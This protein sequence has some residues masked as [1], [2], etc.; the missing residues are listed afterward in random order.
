MSV[1]NCGSEMEDVLGS[2][3]PLNGAFLLQ[4]LL[5]NKYFYGEHLHSSQDIGMTCYPFGLAVITRYY[6][7]ES[8]AFSLQSE[9]LLGRISLSFRSF[10]IDIK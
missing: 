5:S 8:I 2:T 3:G 9:N 1:F 10:L 4:V 6:F 7:V